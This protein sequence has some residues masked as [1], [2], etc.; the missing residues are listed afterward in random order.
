MEKTVKSV[1]FL[2]LMVVLSFQLLTLTRADNTIPTI[3][4]NCKA[5]IISPSFNTPY[6]DLMPLNFTAEWTKGNWTQWIL[7][8]YFYNIDNG[9]RVSIITEP[10]PYIHFE[11]KN[12]T[13]IAI[14]DIIDVSNL[15]NGLH[16]LYIIY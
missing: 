8:R 14:N 11:D 15:T 3:S 9:S 1:V 13:I 7:P 12:P 5:V 10:F 6:T 4:V 16:T 2:L